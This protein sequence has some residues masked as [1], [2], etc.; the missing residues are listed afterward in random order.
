VFIH[1]ADGFFLTIKNTGPALALSRDF[2]QLTGDLFKA[3]LERIIRRFPLP[4]RDE[5]HMAGMAGKEDFF[6]FMV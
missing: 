5:M 4:D 2:D 3:I 6:I 1:A